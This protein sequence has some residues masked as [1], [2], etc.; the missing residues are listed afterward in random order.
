MPKTVETRADKRGKNQV[1]IL[2]HSKEFT[3]LQ[4]ID[5]DATEEEYDQMSKREVN[6]PH[7]E[8]QEDWIGK[9]TI[10]LLRGFNDKKYSLEE[11]I[12]IWEFFVTCIE[13]YLLDHPDTNFLDVSWS[14]SR[15]C[16]SRQLKLTWNGNVTRVGM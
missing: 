4:Y 11:Y 15:D 10:F 9:Q 8:I 6:V 13:A 2:V 7:T 14:L 5:V 3:K 12:Q 16:A 1:E